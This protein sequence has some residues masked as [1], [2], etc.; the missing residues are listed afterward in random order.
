[1]IHSNEF[2]QRFYRL[3]KQRGFEDKH[4]YK[5]FDPTSE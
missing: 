4:D 2:T 3:L 1:M 5:L